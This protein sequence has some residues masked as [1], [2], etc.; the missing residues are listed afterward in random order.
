MSYYS[1]L[2]AKWAT[3]TP[4]TTAQK[5][6]QLNAL[7]VAGTVPT[8]VFAPGHELRN[9]VAAA[10]LAALSAQ[11]TGWLAFAWGTDPIDITSG[12][13]AYTAAVTLFAGKT[14]TLNQLTAVYNKYAAAPQIPW[15]QSVGSNGPVSLA[16]LQLAGNLT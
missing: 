3:L 12:S 6:A 8:T 5:L 16:D 9:A 10:D 2:A 13:L 11:A 1:D 4:G 7:T 14:T 15:W